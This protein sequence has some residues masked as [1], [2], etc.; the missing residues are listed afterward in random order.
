MSSNLVDKMIWP[1]DRLTRFEVARI[2]GARALQISLGAP[3]LIETKEE[4]PIKVAKE[5]FL[6]GMVPITVKR[7]LPDESEV[8]INIRKAIENWVAEHGSL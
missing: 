1:D 5:E 6:K 2:V 8:V 7:E 3:V 4:D